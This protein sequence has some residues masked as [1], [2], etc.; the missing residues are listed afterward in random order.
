MPRWYLVLTLVWS[1]AVLSLP[2][3]VVTALGD[4]LPD[5]VASH[6]GADGVADG[7]T[8]LATAWVWPLVGGGLTVL[9]LVGLG[10][11]TR[12]LRPLAP[13]AIGTATFIGVLG[14]A[15]I[16]AQ[17]DGEAAEATVGAALAWAFVAGITVGVL[18]ALLVR[19]VS[20]VVTT[21]R[22][23]GSL[24]TTV[25]RL[26]TSS[27]NRLVWTGHTRT[28][29]GVRIGGWATTLPLIV[30]A[31]VFAANT[32][33]TMAGVMLG[34]G[35][36]VGLLM[37]AFLGATV[38]VDAGGVRVRSLGITWVK[39]PLSSIERADPVV[40][41][42]GEFGGIG[43]RAQLGSE[44]AIGL[45]TSSGDAVR[46]DRAGQGPFYVTLDPADHVAAVIN[47]LVAAA[48]E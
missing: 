21:Q 38:F 16:A 11:A 35:A 22:R 42:W 27:A 29:R 15:S 8:P 1:A 9:F 40:V 19:R 17:V 12:Q 14:A 43:L 23:R 31:A 6:W 36:I 4:R 30:L 5:P 10:L 41:H 26:R 7:F 32:Q 18:A 37:W 47:T 25:P 45:I 46:V 20:P 24:P 39:V 48:D 34:V 2:W 33:W 3:L 28:S 44:G 13:V